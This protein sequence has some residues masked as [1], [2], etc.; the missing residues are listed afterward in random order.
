MRQ[1]KT[2]EQR[3]M[4]ELHGRSA[5][6]YGTGSKKDGSLM[7]NNADWRNL[8]QT[9]TNATSQKGNDQGEPQNS[10]SMKFSNLQSNIFGLEGKDNQ[11]AYDS[12]VEKAS[13]GTDAN[14][15]AQAASSKIINKGYRQDP[16]RKKQAQL[17]SQVFEQTDYSEYQ[18]MNKP[19][20]DINNLADKQ[21]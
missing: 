10:R 1:Q 4:D 16:Y 20:L 9:H 11:P 17:S 19:K 8:Q 3:K 6:V 5:A 15:T 14:W 7:A 21:R 13:F 2:A 18:P 12:T